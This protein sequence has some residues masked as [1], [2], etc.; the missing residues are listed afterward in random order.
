LK[1]S[2]KMP[3]KSIEPKLELWAHPRTGEPGPEV[4]MY[5]SASWRR[6]Q[7]KKQHTCKWMIERAN[8]MM[9]T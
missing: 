7:I 3:F 8:G 9:C 6:E 2:V 1:E 5:P 4:V